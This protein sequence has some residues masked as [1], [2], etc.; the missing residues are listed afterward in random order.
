MK[1]LINLVLNYVFFNLLIIKYDNFKIKI[2][3]YARE[4]YDILCK[5]MLV[6]ISKIIKLGYSKWST[7]SYTSE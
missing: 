2:N 4:H 7:P 6:W 5:L 1:I 3:Y